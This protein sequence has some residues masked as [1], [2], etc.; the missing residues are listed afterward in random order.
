MLSIP[1]LF[2][3]RLVSKSC[4][5]A[6]GDMA[7]TV[8][9]TSSR[10]RLSEQPT[11]FTRV[12]ELG[13]KS[14]LV[15]YLMP[16]RE[17]IGNQVDY[18]LSGRSQKAD[19]GMGLGDAM[20]GQFKKALC[21]TLPFA[22]RLGLPDKLAT[23]QEREADIHTY[24]DF[25]LETKKV[26][27]DNRFDFIFVHFSIP[28]NPFIYDRFSDNFSMS[29]KAGYIDNLA[30]TD[31]TLGELRSTME[32]AGTW[33]STAVLVTADHWWRDARFFTGRKDHRVVFILKLPDQKKAVRYDPA[34]NNIIT[35][36]LVIAL[37]Q[38]E[39]TDSSGAVRWL[40]KHRS[41][42]ESPT[43]RSLL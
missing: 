7:V 35:A 37:L 11:V 26:L 24:Q 41:F 36:D 13:M 15:G 23:R 3:G 18:V 12:H 32:A 6:S 30:L 5:K 33:D 25:L 39:I 40:D 9:G 43:T 28:H 4:T 20:M 38:G 42:A 10:K 29:R 1:S 19:G 22:V 2:T 16:Y 8:Y 34:F 27:T 17:M 31:R 21:T 14:A